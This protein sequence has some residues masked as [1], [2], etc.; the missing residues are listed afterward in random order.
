MAPIDR[1]GSGIASNGG[2]Y[3][4]KALD[5]GRDFEKAR[6]MAGKAL[7]EV[8]STAV[9]SPLFAEPIVDA[10]QAR[11]VY[12]LMPSTEAEGGTFGYLKQTTRTNNAAEVARGAL[13]RQPAC[14]T[15]RDAGGGCRLA[16][17]R[18]PARQRGELGYVG[19]RCLRRRR[20]ATDPGRRIAIGAPGALPT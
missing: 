16:A 7:L 4:T 14:P 17:G 15:G 5:W 11:F 2:A 13:K 18:L 9:E 3:G 12:Q 6:V 8:G 20:P 19:R 1:C 10:R